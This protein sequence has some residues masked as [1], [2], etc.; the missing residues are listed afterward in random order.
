[1]CSFFS[2][3][4]PLPHFVSELKKSKPSQPDPPIFNTHTLPLSTTLFF[5]LQTLSFQSGGKLRR[6]RRRI[7]KV[8]EKKEKTGKWNGRK[9]QRMQFCRCPIKN[10][11]K[12]F[13]S[14]CWLYYVKSEYLPHCAKNFKYDEVSDCSGSLP[15]WL[16]KCSYVEVKI[17]SFRWIGG[18]I[19]MSGSA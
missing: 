14:P 8:I 1:M 17:L 3:S 16:N 6:M 18:V 7:E 15:L 11:I 9:K 5:I 2:P 13:L 4:P 12:L 19:A 10:L